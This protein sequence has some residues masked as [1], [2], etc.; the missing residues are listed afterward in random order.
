MGWNSLPS[1][2]MHEGVSAV[3][4]SPDG[5]Y[6]L[7]GSSDKTLKLWDVSSGLE[8]RT[9]AG[10]AKWVDSVAF[11]P[12][13]RYALSGGSDKTPKLW[14]VASGQELR[15]FVGHTLSVSSVAFSPNGRF[16]LSGGGDCTTRLWRI[17]TGDEL[18]CMVA[19]SDGEWVVQ[20]AEGYYDASAG[21]HRH[22]LLA[23]GMSVTCAADDPKL[24]LR[25][26][27]PEKVRAFLSAAL[28]G[29]GDSR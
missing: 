26:H 19:F 15:S 6:A 21:G 7:S 8:L 11:S 12:D 17:A 27:N 3:A 22:L 4:F 24:R 25:W 23:Q 29:N 20:T 1:R 2:D 10:H 18:A 14:E 28:D 16:A 9:F 5:R 13:G